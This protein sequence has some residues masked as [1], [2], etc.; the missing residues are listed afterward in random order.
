M[1]PSFVTR[2][3][4]DSNPEDRNSKDVDNEILHVMTHEQRLGLIANKKH[5]QMKRSA[6]ASGP[7]KD[8]DES[9]WKKMDSQLNSIAG[10]AA[11]NRGPASGR[12]HL[13]A[14]DEDDDIDDHE[15][16]SLLPQKR[17]SG[18]DTSASWFKC[19]LKCKCCAWM[20]GAGATGS[21]RMVI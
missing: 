2:H 19:W 9:K 11:E 17:K 1:D 20:T 6:K 5:A 18:D 4:A 10:N 3:S 16:S 13:T 15:V 12:T 14:E 8:A 21:A 7:K